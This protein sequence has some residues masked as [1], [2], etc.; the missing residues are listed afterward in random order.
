MKKRGVAILECVLACLEA[1][2]AASPKMPTFFARRDYAG[3]G[4]DVGERGH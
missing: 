1:A 3:L 4:P 2:N